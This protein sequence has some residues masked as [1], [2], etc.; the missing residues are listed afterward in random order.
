L[1][2]ID[3]EMKANI[4]NDEEL[5]TIVSAVYKN[6]LTLI[7]QLLALFHYVN[8][9]RCYRL[10]QVVSKIMLFLLKGYP[11]VTLSC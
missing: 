11:R 8:I 1:S 6:F 4:T 10:L 9:S 7:F 2:E 5:A 3:R